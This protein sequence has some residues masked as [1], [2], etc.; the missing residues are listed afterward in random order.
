M[1]MNGLAREKEC[2]LFPK[3]RDDEYGHL[4]EL[5]ILSD[6]P[7]Q[8]NAFGAPP[9]HDVQQQQ[10]IVLGLQLLEAGLGVVGDVHGVLRLL[11][12]GFEAL[13]QRQD[14]PGVQVPRDKP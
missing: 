8:G 13:G 7:R 4:A 10:V 12:D 14:G 1:R 2:D 5:G 6:L 9:H 11:Q 3:P